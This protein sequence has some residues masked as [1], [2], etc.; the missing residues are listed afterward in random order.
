MDYLNGKLLRYYKCGF[1]GTGEIYSSLLKLIDMKVDRNRGIEH[2]AWH[3]SHQIPCAGLHAE[4]IRRQLWL[5][6]YQ[7]IL[8]FRGID[9]RPFDFIVTDIAWNSPHVKWIYWFL[10]FIGVLRTWIFVGQRL[11]LYT[12]PN[13]AQ[14]CDRSV[15]V[16]V[17]S[18]CL[19]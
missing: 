7:T 9:R 16:S 3:E 13:L 8:R 15:D 2:G 14:F 10:T 12:E 19:F 1:E 6:S 17:R 18:P 5:R 11:L 4:I